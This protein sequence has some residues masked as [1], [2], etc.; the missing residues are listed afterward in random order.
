MILT[1]KQKRALVEIL[2]N[3]GRVHAT[4]RLAELLTDMDSSFYGRDLDD[5]VLSPAAMALADALRTIG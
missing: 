1:T 2:E 3:G 5:V 4:S